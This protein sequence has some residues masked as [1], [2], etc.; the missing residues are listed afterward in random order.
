MQNKSEL[1]RGYNVKV[2]L[3]C[4]F[5]LDSFSRS[6]TIVKAMAITLQ[7]QKFG[8]R[9]RQIVMYYPCLLAMNKY[10][11]LGCLGARGGCSLRP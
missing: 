8:L 10:K 2:R 6:L 9:T 1:F 4:F 5:N 11:P 3:G 7:F